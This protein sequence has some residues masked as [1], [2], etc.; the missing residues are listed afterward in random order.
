MCGSDFSESAST[1]E[2]NLPKAFGSQSLTRFNGLFKPEKSGSGHDW[3]AEQLAGSCIPQPSAAR[4]QYANWAC[5]PDVLMGSAFSF[6]SELLETYTP[7]LHS[8]QTD[9]QAKGIWL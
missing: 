5:P 4:G 7:S 6:Q 8:G 9:M 2:L 1:L 3:R